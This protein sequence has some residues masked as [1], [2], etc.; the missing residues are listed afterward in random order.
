MVCF[1]LF[2]HL[3]VEVAGLQ[4]VIIN[5]MIL[6]RSSSSS[7]SIR[8][9]PGYPGRARMSSTSTILLLVGSP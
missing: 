9:D 6:S 3:Q 8:H 7:P 2:Q 5:L 1:G 4:V